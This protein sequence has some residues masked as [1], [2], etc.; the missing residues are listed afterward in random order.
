MHEAIVRRLIEAI[1][2]KIKEAREVALQVPDRLENIPLHEI[3]TALSF[4]EKAL[5]ADVVGLRGDVAAAY[6]RLW[7][8]RFPREENQ[9]LFSALADLRD[10]LMELEQAA[11]AA[12]YPASEATISPPSQHLVP[13]QSIAPE[14]DTLE[15]RLT[16]LDVKLQE[17]AIRGHEAGSSSFQVA[18][19]ESIVIDAGTKSEMARELAAETQVDIKGL[20]HVV[21]GI[22]R[23]V[24]AFQMTVAPVRARVSGIVKGIARGL[25]SAASGVMR[26][27]L[28]VFRKALGK[29]YPDSSSIVFLV[30]DCDQFREERRVPGAGVPFQDR[31]IEDGKPLCGPEMVVVPS[32]KFIMGSPDD[33]P[34]R[35]NR[36]S[37]Q[38]EVKLP[39]PFA[40]GR[41]AVT[42]GQFSVFVAAT[43]YVANASWRAPGFL[44]DDSHPVVCVSWNDA[45]A[46][47]AWLSK[48]SGTVYRLPSEAEWEYACRAGTVTPFW[49]GPSITPE[50]ANYDG[51]YSFEGGGIQG[52]FRGQ[53]M[54]ARSF[55]ANPWGLYQVHGNVWEWCD[56]PWHDR[57]ADKPDSVKAVGGAWTIKGGSDRVLR[58]GSWNSDPRVLR[59]A[60]RNRFGPDNRDDYLGFR[61]ARTITPSLGQPHQ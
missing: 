26:A 14:L 30:R 17:L 23:I 57:Y 40:I 45:H 48:A 22:G 47:L 38:H 9:R 60:Y 53:T 19:I 11:A 51:N 35:S 44:Q 5:R 32:G 39:R 27:G 31:W 13:R 18:I 12:E 10:T 54:P 4:A 42:R 15:Q 21:E 24:E 50:R 52:E 1:D 41:C 28:L 36:E 58:G 6:A 8:H 34:G 59:S 37:P 16:E 25:S 29:Q 7:R 46:Y 43:R 61:V 56:D 20:A 55:E 2:E 33:E 49:W 3:E